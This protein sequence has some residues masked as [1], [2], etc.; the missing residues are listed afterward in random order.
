MTERL[1][2]AAEVLFEDTNR[3]ARVVTQKAD[4]W[5]N[6]TLTKGTAADDARA[7]LSQETARHCAPTG[8]PSE[9]T[10]PG[11]SDLSID[12]TKPSQRRGG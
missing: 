9:P 6:Y 11:C 2:G 8:P 4:W 12:F 1:Q 10:G 3:V 5:P 7:G